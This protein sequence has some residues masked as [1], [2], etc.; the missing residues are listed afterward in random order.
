MAAPLVGVLQVL[1]CCNLA[2]WYIPYHLRWPLRFCRAWQRTSCHLYRPMHLCRGAS[3]TASLHRLV[4][5]HC[6]NCTSCRRAIAPGRASVRSLYL[7]FCRRL[8]PCHG[9]LF[10]CRWMYL[11]HLGICPCCRFVRPCRIGVRS[12]CRFARLRRLGPYFRCR[13]VRP[14]RLG[15]CLHCRFVR[16]RR[17][18]I[19][20]HCR[21]VRP[22]RLGMCFHCRFVR[23]RRPG[24][25]F[26]CR[27]V[28]PRRPG[29]CFHCRFVRR[30]RPGY[31]FHCRFVRP[32]RPGMCFHCRFVRRRRPGNCFHCRFVHLRRLGM[33]FRCRL[34]RRR[35]RRR[36]WPVHHQP[37]LMHCRPRAR[38][39]QRGQPWLLRSL[40]RPVQ[41]GRLVCLLYHGSR[42]VHHRDRLI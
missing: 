21:F 9:V 12:R 24:I 11:C 1:V 42:L 27:F 15:M 30:R 18:G 13:F 17:P 19:P 25:H 10:H 5:F 38:L 6:T 40:P 33:C 35:L 36:P 2:M 26:P 34:V 14:R 16:R 39:V 41:R 37:R 3:V 22:C 29:M 8:Q 7:H 23:R 28:R 32:R 31:Y 20:P 4:H